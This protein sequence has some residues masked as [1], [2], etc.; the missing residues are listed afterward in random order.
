MS[1]TSHFSQIHIFHPPELIF[2]NWRLKIFYAFCTVLYQLK[3]KQFW[4]ISKLWETIQRDFTRLLSMEK[5]FLF[6]VFHVWSSVSGRHSKQM[7]TINNPIIP[8]WCLSMHLYCYAAI[9][10]GVNFR[11]N[12]PRVYTVCWIV[13]GLSWVI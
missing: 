9:A 11:S 3:Q 6:Y 10:S 4:A 5:Y 13:S 8:G 12:L 1:F 2:E 7:S